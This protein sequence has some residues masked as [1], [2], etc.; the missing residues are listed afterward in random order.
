MAKSGKPVG[1]QVPPRPPFGFSDWQEPTGK[2]NE[3][4]GGQGVEPWWRF[5]GQSYFAGVLPNPGIQSEHSAPSHAQVAV[6]DLLVFAQG[7]GGATPGDLAFFDQIMAVGD[8]GKHVHILVDNED[9]LSF[10]LEALQA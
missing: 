10:G 5:K 8:A 9:R 1:E 6:H 7:G 3:F 2:H 4:N